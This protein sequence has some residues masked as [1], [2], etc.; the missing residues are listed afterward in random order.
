MKKSLHI[1]IVMAG[2]LLCAP[3]FAQLQSPLDIAL[4]HLESDYK[5]MGLTAA[6]I[7]DVVVSDNIRSA[8]NGM[9][10]I[11]FIQRYNGIEI[12]NAIMNYTV[13][14][15]GKV[16]YTGNRFIPEIAGKING[17]HA[18]LSAAEAVLAAAKLLGVANIDKPRLLSQTSDNSFIFDKGELSRAD[19]PVK[20]RYQRMKDGSLKLA[21][22]MAI[23]YKGGRDYWS[24]RIDAI[25]GELLDKNSFTVH[26]SHGAAAHTSQHDE[27]SDEHAV[28]FP[29][30]LSISEALEKAHTALAGNQYRVL[31]FPLENPKQGPTELVDNP[32][33][34]V[35]SPFGWHDLDGV[36]GSDTKITRGNNVHAYQDRD[37]D[38]AS[39]NDEP[40]GGD[41]LIFDIPYNYS[42]EPDKFTKSA[43]LQLFYAINYLHDFTFNFGF[44]EFSNFQLKNYSGTGQGN[45][46][47]IAL[48]QF[49]G[50]TLANVNNADFSTPGDGGNGRVRM[51]LWDNSLTSAKSLIVTAPFDIVGSYESA[52]A[53]F[54]ATITYNNP[55]SGA[56]IV[57][58]DGAAENPTFGCGPLSKGNGSEVS[59]KIAIIDRGT[60][61]FG[62]KALN[63][64]KAGAVGCIICNFEEATVNM[65][66]GAEGGQV[67]IPVLS[68]KKSICDKLKQYAGAGGLMV[69]IQGP[70]ENSSGPLLLDGSL[71]NGIIAHEF[72][73]GVSIRLTG[74][75]SNSGC[76]SNA[77]Q[78]GEGWSDFLALVTTAKA[79][80]TKDKTRG[81]GTYVTREDDNGK[82]IRTFPYSLNMSINPHT[83][84]DIVS[85]TEVHYIG[86]VWNTILWDLYWAMADKYG[87]DP[88]YKNINS[89]SYK[90]VQLVMDAMKI[91]PC[92]P[93]FADGRDAILA[94]DV[95]NNNGE[96]ACLIWEVFARRG[97]GFFASQGDSDAA[98]DA[99]ENFDPKPICLNKITIKKEATPLI[100]AGEEIEYKI[101][102]SN[103]KS[104]PATGTIVTDQIPSGTTV[105]NANGGVV[106]G[107]VISFNL[108]T[109]ASGETK[110][111]T[112]TS[113]TSSNIWSQRQLFDDAETLDYWDIESGEGSDFW[114]PTNVNYHSA[115]TSFGI[116][117][118]GEVNKHNLKYIGNYKVTGDRP[119]L[120]FYHNYETEPGADG[121]FVEISTNNGTSWTNL[122][123]KFIRNGYPSKIAYATFTLPNIVAFSGNS[124]GWIASYIDL[125][126]FKGQDIIVRWRYGSDE[127]IGGVGWFIDDLEYMDLKSYN[128]EACV[129]TNEGDTDCASAPQEGTIIESQTLSSSDL[130][131]GEMSVF[132]NPASDY[133][134]ISLKTGSTGNFDVNIVTLD[135]RVIK[136]QK[137]GLTEGAN[138]QT[139]SVHG[140]PSGCYMIKIQ[141]DKEYFINKII[142]K[143]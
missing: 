105:S 111:I 3:A 26:C 61:E 92:S 48:S 84:G 73:H 112:Y 16:V 106:S 27:C 37:A 83:Y 66:A 91:Q 115:S 113:V 68:V 99:V 97:L 78:M 28:T 30:N 25:T 32:A 107:D 41:D 88:T 86:E 20:L 77:E 4:R 5:H 31:P 60:C 11:Y 143:D 45:D 36:P 141:N 29:H 14:K 117:D 125:S 72:G 131:Q 43:V 47:V 52:N 50:N 53:S 93:G 87:Y 67:T 33:D 1:I 71:D 17:T 135:G 110:T 129:N 55:V 8:Q 140:I 114:E 75:P 133:L 42:Q 108:G 81:V 95:I 6:D 85:N 38:Y 13:S 124:N 134:N 132:P 100:N 70:P 109:L 64:Q 15:D 57:V 90:A 19:I 59:G 39:S 44:D 139:I 74:G 7:Q 89:G 103:Y 98:G 119:V 9:T 2:F 123:N 65:G 35:A 121:G 22:D 12:Y 137:I 142:L 127:Q 49:D 138:N 58:N 63:A 23:D 120:R 96:N 122:T 136:S 46:H 128:G 18:K 69:T 130:K 79:G 40:D 94:A 54:G 51:F 80:D 10:N 76:L 21:W 126:E 102:V 118:V 104:T 101:T 24:M 34:P 82:G 62:T 116:S 56:A